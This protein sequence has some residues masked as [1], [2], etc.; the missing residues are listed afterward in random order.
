MGRNR[1]HDYDHN[2]YPDDDQETIQRDGKRVKRTDWKRD[3]RNKR[4]EKERARDTLDPNGNV[5]Y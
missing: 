1:N 3:R 5:D 4:R 2:D